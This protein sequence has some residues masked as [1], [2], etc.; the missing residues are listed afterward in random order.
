MRHSNNLQA[1]STRQTRQCFEDAS[2][3]QYL[4]RATPNTRACRNQDGSC[5]HL[6]LREIRLVA[7]YSFNSFPIQLSPEHNYC[8]SGFFFLM[9]YAVLKRTI[10]WLLGLMSVVG[11]YVS[12]HG[13]YILLAYFGAGLVWW[14]NLALSISGP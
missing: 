11:V 4:A 5:A 14:A 13:I 3:V 2:D 8:I 6:G 1:L 9:N 12:Y 10:A 7:R